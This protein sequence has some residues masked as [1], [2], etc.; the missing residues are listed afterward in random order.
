M[1]RTASCPSCQGRIFADD[2]FCSWC[3]E[4]VHAKESRTV[5]TSRVLAA[6]SLGTGNRQSCESCH[7]PILQEDLYCASCGARCGAEPTGGTQADGWANIPAQI[8]EASGGKYEFV[9]ELGRGGMGIV[10]QARDKELKRNV[11]IKVLASTWL[12]DETMVARF[13][14]EA[15]TIASLNHESIV[16]VFEVRRAG[17]LHY[18]VMDYVEGASLSRVIRT[19]GPLPI[20]VV[21]AVLYRVGLALSHAHRPKPEVIIHRDVKPSNIMLDPEGNVVV[22]DFGISK[23][24]ER[25]S[26]LTSTGLVM[27]TPEYMSPEQ[28]RGHTVTP[29]SDQYA[30]GTVVY[31]MLTGAPPFTGP[32]YQVLM[33]H[34]MEPVPS[35]LAARAD[36]PPALAA[37]TEKMLA[38]SPGDRWPT[39]R[40]MLKSLGL[41]PFDQDDPVL[42]Q[43]GGLVREAMLNT[44]PWPQPSPASAPPD[45]Q[46]TPTSIRIV[47][48]PQDL[49]VG[50]EVAL[51]ATVLFHDGAQEQGERV[52]WESTDPAIV[53]VDPTTGQMVAVG[54]GSAMVTASGDGVIGTLAVDVSAPRVA[55]VAID[56]PEV[57]L[58]AGS[59]LQ[60][61]ARTKSKRGAGLERTVTW[62]SSDPRIATVSNQGV[63]T[64]KQ[65]GTVSVLAHCDGVGAAA[66]LTVVAEARAPARADEPVA[67]PKPVVAKEVAERPRAEAKPKPEKKPAAKKQPKAAPR[68]TGTSQRS[69]AKV[70]VIAAVAVGGSLLLWTMLRPPQLIAFD[71]FNQH[72]QR[73]EV[74]GV[75]VLPEEL[76]VQLDAADGS[77]GAYRLSLAGVGVQSL[78]NQIAQRGV[79]IEAG[80]EGSVRVRTVTAESGEALPGSLLALASQGN[81]G[82]DPCD[83]AGDHVLTAGWYDVELRDFQWRLDSIQVVG[84]DG[85]SETLASGSR[86]FV[87]DGSTLSVTAA[88][89]A[90]NLR[91]SDPPPPVNATIRIVTQGLPPGASIT[92]D[93]RALAS[94]EGVELTPGDHKLVAQARNYRPDSITVTAQAGDSLSWS[95]RLAA[96]EAAAGRGGRATPGPTVITPPSTTRWSDRFA[97]A[98]I[99]I[100]TFL[101]AVEN[102]GLDGV[103]AVWSDASEADLQP[104]RTFLADK[105]IR[106]ATM[107]FRAP[108]SRSGSEAMFP[109]VTV[110]FTYS[111]PPNSPEQQSVPRPLQFVVYQDGGQWRIRS[112]TFRG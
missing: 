31:A 62:S 51:K 17:S 107:V 66:V 95:P 75:Q 11:A 102:A 52:S 3:G 71:V 41:K 12:T 43:I 46:H 58:E 105:R 65:S 30:L 93:G 74:V 67:T 8:A 7:S 103:R 53:R 70:A 4:R 47:P 97:S 86:L 44:A 76:E 37:A 111:S 9:R 79:P 15:R 28:C 94:T 27:G 25:P 87:P 5:N 2:A 29:A 77:K 63:V 73:G 14:N 45:T 78:L 38:K 55:Q 54:P 35:V 50:D 18:F 13:Q 21:E 69:Y 68:P 10:F 6:R 83:P 64:A 57:K 60:L 36:C 109:V 23:A 40:D 26:G 56:P 34:Q 96:V 89:S 100:D 1:E 20:P 84:A 108:S 49:E 72:L 42:L 24:S 104:W 32:F 80:G 112:V 110:N 92:L 106:A 99:A 39:I 98:E 90:L 82:C 59:T 19:H 85:A 33:A 88:L 16:T 81:Q 91:P 22:M 48:S 101:I 61:R